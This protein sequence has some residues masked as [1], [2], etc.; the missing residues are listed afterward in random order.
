M[1]IALLMSVATVSNAQFIDIKTY[2]LPQFNGTGQ[3]VRAP[4]G[5]LWFT[6]GTNKIGRITTE[7]VVTDYPLVTAN[8][9]ANSITVGPDGNLWFTDRSRQRIGRMTTAGT[10]TEFPLPIF[11]FLGLQQIT[12]GPDGALWFTEDGI[13]QIGRLSAA[14]V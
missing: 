10:L 13:D 7:G 11:P 4:D 5:A 9:R 6:T 8:S 2:H 12:A 1:L 14:G 3:I